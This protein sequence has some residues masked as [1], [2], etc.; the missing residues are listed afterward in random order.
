MKLLY[1]I[2]DIDYWLFRHGVAP[3]HPLRRFLSWLNFRA[4]RWVRA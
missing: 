2:R 3:I 4:H 1:L